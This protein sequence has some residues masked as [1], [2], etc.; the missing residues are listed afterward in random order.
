MISGVLTELLYT[1]IGLGCLLLLGTFLRAKI[2]LLQQLFLPASV[3]GGFIG[4]LIGPN[5]WPSGGLTLLP[6][7]WIS[8]CSLLPGLLNT[9]VVSAIPLTMLGRSSVGARKSVLNASKVFI[10]ILITFAIQIIIGL[11]T[12]YIFT[13][14]YGLYNTFGYELMAGY[15]GGHSTT[16]VLGGL[17][18]ELGLPYWELAQ[19]VS[20]TTATFGLVGGMILGIVYLNIMTRMGK[21]SVLDRPSKL[22]TDML[23]GLRLDPNTQPA[24]GYETTHT[25]T[26]ESITFH[27]SLILVCVGI[28]YK[29]VGFIKN[30]NI[31]LLSS[32]NV[33]IFCI[34]VMFLIVES[35]KQMGL[36]SLIDSKTAS[37]IS[38]VSIDFIITAAL[39]S[40]PIQIVL[41][42]ALPILVMCVA[43][44]VMTALT[45][46]VACKYAFPDYHVERV[47]SMWGSCTGTY[48]TGI[49]LLKM[50]DPDYSLP[51]MQEYSTGF[52]ISSALSYIVMSVAVPLMLQYSLGLNI[53]FHT[54]ILGITVISLFIS[55]RVPQ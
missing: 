4:L 43:G 51:V 31:P 6:D 9:F 41:R 36:T 42:Y 21:A 47:L 14:Q 17:L 48:T 30:H 46:I 29:A 35:F 27:L 3:I 1:F 26:I 34:P 10:I 18:S 52:I 12:Q 54:V 24:L 38:G 53:L 49:T 45:L 20:A 25:S 23:Q 19:G 50:A 37:K 16:G 32:L 15:N 44:Y 8:I 22:P 33:Q 40:M 2:P 13:N 28:S 7:E 11:V 5:V 55:Q 39:S